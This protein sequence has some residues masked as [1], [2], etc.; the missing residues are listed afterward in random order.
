VIENYV[1]ERKVLRVS[2]PL[3]DI[4]NVKTIQFSSLRLTPSYEEERF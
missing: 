1:E 3:R 4:E 2:T